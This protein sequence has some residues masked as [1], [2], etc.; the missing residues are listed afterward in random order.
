MLKH[1]GL[2]RKKTLQAAEQNRPD[3]GPGAPT[4]ARVAALHGCKP[5]RV[6]RRDRHRH[7]HD[8]PLWQGGVGQQVVDA[9]P[10]GHWLTT[11]LVAGVEDTIQAVEG[12]LAVPAE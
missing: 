7:Y 1:M 12:H 10:H 3:V 6:P 9:V 11:I 8:A 4:L 2:T 5:L